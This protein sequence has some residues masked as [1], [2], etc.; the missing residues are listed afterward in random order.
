MAFTKIQNLH[1]VKKKN[2]LYRPWC[3][4]GGGGAASAGAA[5]VSRGEAGAVAVGG[6]GAQAAPSLRLLL[7]G[8]LRRLRGLLGGVRAASALASAGWND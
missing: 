6:L 4:S 2:Q 8:L 3:C 5:S 1:D 7:P